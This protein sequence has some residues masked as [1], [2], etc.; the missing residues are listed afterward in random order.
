MKNTNPLHGK[1]LQTIVE[2]LVEFYGFETNGVWT[3]QA[4]VD[5]AQASG[6]TVENVQNYFVPGGLKIVDQNGDN[7][8]NLDDRKVIGNPYPDFI[9]GFTNNFT[10]KN[11]QLGLTLQGVQGGSIINGDSFYTENRQRNS[12]LIE[13]RWISAANPGDGQTPFENNGVQWLLTDY[14]VEDA[15]YASLR[16]VSLS[17]TLGEA[18]TKK[19]GL[20]GMRLYTSAQNL[21]FLTADGYTG[22]NPEARRQ[23]GTY[24]SALID[25]YH[26][27]GFPIPR[28]IIFGV[29]INF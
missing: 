27:G 21:F 17:Y 7:K 15:S 3:S 26:R 24:S 29:E 16:E 25:G 11:L 5:A 6:Q 1:T 23:S 14:A 8:I 9:W 18:V 4:E 19:I 22:I 2:F 10:Y 28:T 12:N 20:N 13:N